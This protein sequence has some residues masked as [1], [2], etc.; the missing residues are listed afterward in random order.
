MSRYLPHALL[1]VLAL[2]ALVAGR[3]AWRRGSAKRPVLM[4]ALVLSWLPSL[5][6]LLV[7]LRVLEE[8]Y[9]R[10]TRP[11]ATGVSVVAMAFAV[12]RLLSLVRRQ[13]RTRVWLGDLLVTTAVLSAALAVAGP[14][15]GRPLDRMA[16]IVL[17]DRSRSIELVANVERRIQTELSVVE[18]DMRDHDRIGT[19]VFGASAATETPLRTKNEDPAPQKV[20]IGR[21]ASDIAAGLRRALSEVPSD[22]AARV[23]L[24]SDGVATRGDPLAAAA[25]AVASDVPVDVVALEQS[26]VPDVRVVSLRAPPRLADEQTFELRMVV[27]SP[28]AAAVEL[29]LQHDGKLVRKDTIRIDKGENIV[30]IAEKARGPGLH[31]YDVALT[32]LDPKI[33]YT[34]DDNVAS[35]FVRV[36]GTA[37][38][39][40]VDG[41]AGKTAFVAGALEAVGF[42]V[43]EGSFS[44]LPAEI[45]GMAAYDL[46]VFGDVAARHLAAGQLAAFGSYVRDLGGGLLLT[47]GPDSFGPGGFSGTPIEEIAPVGFDLKQEKRRASL[48][49]V[50]GI[51]ISGSMGMTVGAHTK[52]ELANEAAARS[53][54]LLGKGD[55]LGVQ[56]VDTAVHWTVRLAPVTDK[57][58][59]DKAIRSVNSG[60]GG[61]YVDI[62]L[63]E[64]YTTLR[65]ADVNLKHVLVFADG[66]DAERITP[67]VKQMVSTAFA[68]GITTSFVALGQ[69]GDVADLEEMARRGGGR[70]YLVEDATRLPAVFQQ[71]TILASKSAI[72]EEPF[73]ARLSIPSPVSAGV[74][75]REAPRLEGYVITLPK[76]RSQV[77]LR[78]PEDDPLLAMWSVGLGQ[79]AVFTSDLKDRWGASWTRWQGA[80]RMVAQLGRQLARGEDDARVRLEAEAT[81]GELRVRA[82]VVDDDGR[83]QSFRRLR[84]HVSGPDGFAQDLPL[85]ATSAGLYSATVPLSRPGAYIAV[86]RDELGGKPLATTGAALSPG[87]ELRPTGSDVALLERLAELTGGERRDTLAGLFR[88]RPERRFAYQDITSW[89]ATIA[90]FALLLAVAARRLSLPILSRAMAKLAVWRPLARGDEAAPAPGGR[91]ADATLAS[92][93]VKRG[94]T[95]ASRTQQPA[96]A[97]V[98]HRGGPQPVRPPTSASLLA[99]QTNTQPTRAP[100]RPPP[101]ATSV[102][103]RDPRS[104]RKGP[105]PSADAATG[106]ASARHLTAAEILLKRRRGRRR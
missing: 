93:L 50:I 84:V 67:A 98:T 78:A 86:A 34:A 70:F 97:V 77:L 100:A 104:A 42:S 20:Q 71:E 76:A 39:L 15:F 61:I 106:P 85:E 27:A 48:A 88:D 41:S 74:D 87:E 18:A 38:A 64:A 40:V 1:G 2:V 3:A 94:E 54:A 32:A 10:F 89:L 33:D 103:A 72:S 30:R 36:R 79:C 83:A 31:R 16:V 75:F 92:L 43:D 6:V 28:E 73:D 35:A 45:D 17:L 22:A 14:E 56:H 69:G 49:E 102:Q 25:A 81:A 19:V 21:D 5:Y 13:R 80:A 11:W 23:V 58:A 37:R 26:D 63:K 57:D 51:D 91:T 96:S 101:V 99:Q 82:N 7:W 66:S 46:I 9:V 8:S 47:G 65:A 60:G 24:I 52:L 90:A 29:R 55:Q 44:A 53:A 95:A 68:G 62:T 12:L 105:A 59:I 4:A